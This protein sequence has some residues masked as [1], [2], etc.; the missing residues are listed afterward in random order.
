MAL[1]CSD[2]LSALAKVQKQIQDAEAE[3][4]ELKDLK[5]PA[6]D[7]ARTQVSHRLT[8]LL[9]R[10]GSMLRAQYDGPAGP[11]MHDAG[12]AALILAPCLVLPATAH[13]SESGAPWLSMVL[14][15]P[16][17]SKSLPCA[18]VLIGGAVV[19]PRQRG[20]YTHACT[21]CLMAAMH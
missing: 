12:V 15:L 9:E 20:P 14:R 7:P 4:Q 16:S 8:L 2:G 10:E 21:D 17:S 13:L 18:V 19:P 11:A 6:N 1:M 5:V 3:L